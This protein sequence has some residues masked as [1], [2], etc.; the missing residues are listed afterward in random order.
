MI[1]PFYDRQ[2]DVQ[3]GIKEKTSSRWYCEN[4]LQFNANYVQY[5]V[6]HIIPYEQG[7][8]GIFHNNGKKK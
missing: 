5:N 2:A 3:P 6:I 4:L 8:S 7:T 1:I